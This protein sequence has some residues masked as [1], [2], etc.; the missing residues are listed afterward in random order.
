MSCV[1]GDCGDIRVLASN[2]FYEKERIAGC[3]WSH[4]GSWSGASGFHENRA[5]VDLHIEEMH[6]HI[7]ICDTRTLV[8]KSYIHAFKACG[9]TIFRRWDMA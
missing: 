9:G 1:R 8:Q 6:L 5:I 7:P 2:T 3:A 4:L